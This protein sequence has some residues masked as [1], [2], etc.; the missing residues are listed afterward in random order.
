MQEITQTGYV[1]ERP[2][3]HVNDNR[4]SIRLGPTRRPLD[5][6]RQMAKVKWPSC[7]GALNEFFAPTAYRMP[8]VLCSP[9]DNQG[10]R[11]ARARRRA[12]GHS[13]LGDLR[14]DD[15]IMP[16]LRRFENWLNS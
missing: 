1:I 8:E 13:M 15:Q 10:F 7:L 12:Q 5:A 3:Q 11:P 6:N 16:R 9:F 14:C 4:R 2:L